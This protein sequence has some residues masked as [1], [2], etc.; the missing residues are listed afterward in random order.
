VISDMILG[1]LRRE[2]LCAGGDRDERGAGGGG[3]GQADAL[4]H[5]P[6][7]RQARVRSM[8]ATKDAH[9]MTECR[10]QKLF[11]NSGWLACV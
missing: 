5:G 10:I 2:R 4:A 9:Q 3:G 1:P 6:N 8:I 11:T 7:P